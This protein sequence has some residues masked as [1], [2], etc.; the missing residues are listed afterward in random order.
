MNGER[1]RR[2]FDDGHR[3]R[4]RFLIHRFDYTGLF[5]G[6]SNYSLHLVSAGPVTQVSK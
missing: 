1:L 5:N 6:E 4:G 3:I 2:A